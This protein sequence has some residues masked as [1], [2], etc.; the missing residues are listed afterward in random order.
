M[1]FVFFFLPSF[2]LLEKRCRVSEMLIMWKLGF[3]FF[4]FLPSP[5]FFINVDNDHMFDVVI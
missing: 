4:F 2:L 1:L 5:F 3:F